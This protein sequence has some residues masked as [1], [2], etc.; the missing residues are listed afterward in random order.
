MVT[1]FAREID[2]YQKHKRMRSEKHR[3]NVASLNCAICGRHGPSQ[4][5][6]VNATKGIG[7][8]ACDSLTFPAC[9]DC[10]REH[11]TGRRG[12]K[13]EWWTKE[14]ELVDYTRAQLLRLNLWTKE[15]EEHYKRAI[16]PIARFVNAYR[17]DDEA[18]NEL[19]KTNEV[20]E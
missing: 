12:E 11:D 14:W 4:C 18:E 19:D 5:A 16:E 8:K 9:P 7:I 6:H 15:I 2:L 10:H 13:I 3:R 17:F 1:N 20:T